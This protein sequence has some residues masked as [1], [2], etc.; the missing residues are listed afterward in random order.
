M[1]RNFAAQEESRSRFTLNSFVSIGE[2]LSA[3][4][5]N[6]TVA[7]IYVSGG[8]PIRPG[9]QYF[10]LVQRNIDERFT[11]GAPDLAMID[12]PRFDFQQDLRRTIGQLNRMN[13][14]IYSLD[15]KGLLLNA[16]GADRNDVQAAH[17]MDLLSRN[18]QLQDSLVHVAQETGGLAFVN[19]QNY[20]K[21]LAE[22]IRDMNEQYLL[23]GGL[24]STTKKGA[25]HQI[26]VKVSRPGVKVRH[27]KGYVD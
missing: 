16:R 21:G 13:V 9:E 8:F 14:T 2:Y 19:G 25:Y 12:R 26:K 4:S 11:A 17:G 24:Q 15:A 3:H 27:R 10:D 6:G 22:I 1:A 5:L 18:Y 23:C 7:L 20:Q